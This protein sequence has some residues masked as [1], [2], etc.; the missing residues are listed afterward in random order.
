MIVR[1][2]FDAHVS[3]N[4]DMH[5]ED[6]MHLVMDEIDEGDSIVSVLLLDDT[7]A[8][9]TNYIRPANADTGDAERED[10]SEG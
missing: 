8:T 10:D 6:I 5:P 7:E 1:I 4:V 3:D 2:T 9:K